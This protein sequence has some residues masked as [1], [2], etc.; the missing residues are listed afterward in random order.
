MFSGNPGATAADEGVYLV[1]TSAGA[2]ARCVASVFRD[3]E[4]EV[5]SF[6]REDTGAEVDAI[7]FAAA[8][9]QEISPGAVRPRWTP[10]S[11]R[12]ALL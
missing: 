9:D 8:I 10:Q 7:Q 11:A 4:R 2:V 1:E 5:V 12:E 6:H 3:G